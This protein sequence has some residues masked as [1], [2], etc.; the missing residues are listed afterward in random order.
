MKI[1]TANILLRYYLRFPGGKKER[2]PN[3]SMYDILIPDLST[4]IEFK[5]YKNARAAI[6]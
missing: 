1:I 6:L 3:S 5:L 4:C 2:P